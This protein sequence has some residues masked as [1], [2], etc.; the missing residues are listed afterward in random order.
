MSTI[1]NSY[2][3]GAVNGYNAVGGLVGSNINSSI[4]ENSYATASVSGNSQGVGGLVGYNFNSSTI[5][6]SYA[7]GSVSGIGNG[8]GGLVGYNSNTSSIDNSYATG[9]VSGG[10]TGGLIADDDGTNTLTNNW[11]YNN[12][13]NGIGAGA[14]DTGNT[15]TG[16]WQEA[17]G[18]SDF[19][20]SGSGTGG[21]VYSGWDF[22]GLW[23]PTGTYPT[24]IW[25]GMNNGSFI[26]GTCSRS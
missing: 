11:W 25:Q 15:S 21:A 1:D 22:N 8:V 2:A 13:N 5:D 6:N 24:L 18:A 7:T 20:G 17:L 3:T 14:G 23:N 12:L 16:N 9:T 26:G 4:I 10:S 19:Y